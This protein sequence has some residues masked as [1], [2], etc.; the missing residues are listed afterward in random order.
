M[1]N[2]TVTATVVANL[3]AI[4]QSNIGPFWVSD[5]IGAIIA[6]NGDGDMCAYRTTDGG[7]GWTEVEAEDGTVANYSAW[8]D[9][10]NLAD[11]GDGVHVAWMDDADDEVKYARFDVGAGT[12][13]S[14]VTVQA[15]VPPNAS[16]ALNS[17]FVGKARSGRLYLGYA[18]ASTSGA[19]E[20]DDGSTWTAIASPWE[21]NVGDYTLPAVCNTGDNNDFAIIFWDRGANEISIKLY[22][23]S[24]D[25]WGETSVASSVT[26]NNNFSARWAA[27][28][29]HSDG[30]VILVAL[31]AV[32]SATGDMLAWALEIDASPSASALTNALTDVDGTWGTGLFI[33]PN[34]DLYACYLRG[35]DFAANDALPYYKLSTDDGSSWGSETSISDASA[36]DF[37][38]ISGG[39]V[40][41]VGTGGRFLPGFVDHDADDL[42]VNLTTD[43]EFLAATEVTVTGAQGAPTGTIAAQQTLLRSVSGSKGAPE[44]QVASLK[45]LFITPE[46]AAGAPSGAVT[47]QQMLQRSIS[48]QP[49]APSGTVENTNRFTIQGAVGNPSATITALWTAVRPAPFLT[50]GRAASR[51]LPKG[52]TNIRRNGSL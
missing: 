37:R 18:T 30:K 49:A 50:R 15:S 33:A 22:D 9:R 23:E 27:S 14:V 20:S 25:S 17:C 5:Q 35:S 47:A 4:A 44:G 40:G 3:R 51:I 12:W 29:R 46:G 52:R 7:A 48:G 42:L 24:G 32:D 26:P 39:V 13:G 16:L 28:T 34:D 31:S 8:F 1:A 38:Q 19:E 45:A 43:V 10:Q 6:P 2:T 36:S 11:E 21:S 41:G